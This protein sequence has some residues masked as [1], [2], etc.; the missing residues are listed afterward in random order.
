MHKRCRLVAH[1]GYALRYPE[2]T[3]TA[4]RAA[5]DAGADCV[6]MDVQIAADGV[7]VVLHDADIQ[8]V[9]GRNGQVHRLNSDALRRVSVHEPDRLGNRF[10]GETIPTLADACRVL[11]DLPPSL[12]FIEVKDDT[13]EH[14]QL[15]AVM[16]RI[17]RDSAPLGRRRVIV[18]FL[19]N[20]VQ[21]AASLEDIAIGWVLTDYGT[22]S[23]E[24]ARTL[25][26]DFL[27]CNR[28]LL[29]VGGAP[30]AEGPWD[31]V[32]YEVTDPVE[33]RRLEHRGV[34]FIETMAVGELRRALAGSEET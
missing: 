26:P 30:L 28:E 25:E 34:R 17:L 31:W 21:Q 16:Q 6:E 27:F 4:F 12:V 10:L 23:L 29:P 15:P 20:V 14:H 33:V 24:R 22:A 7:P 18:S 9:S 19:D 2:N 8:R 1:R 3:L 11:A 13:L 32:I 5:L